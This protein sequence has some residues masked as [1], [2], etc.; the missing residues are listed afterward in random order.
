V[1]PECLAV[2]KRTPIEGHPTIL[3]AAAK[4]KIVCVSIQLAEQEAEEE[5]KQDGKL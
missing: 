4:D 2:R 5:E 1:L 3:E